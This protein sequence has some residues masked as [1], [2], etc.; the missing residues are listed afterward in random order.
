MLTCDSCKD[1]A[2]KGHELEKMPANCPMRD[3]E[4]YSAIMQE[5]QK[6]ENAEFLIQCAYV[7]SEGYGQWNRVRE[8]VELC[9]RM[10]YRKVGV[11]FCIGLK[12]EAKIFCK[13]LRD[14]GIAVESI[15]CKNGSY[16]KTEVGIPE[17]GKLKPGK[18]EPACNPVAQAWFLSQTDA[19]LFVMIG[20]CVGHDSLFLRYAARYTDVPVT[21]LAVKDR[22]TGH[23]PCAALYGAEGFFKKTFGKKTD[24]K[25]ER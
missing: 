6:E 15:C 21:V 22:V 10:N 17:D 23:N 1:V 11:A 25:S 3:T 20:L 13:I 2:C 16:D 24:E 18:F 9:R 5:Y 8:I 19:D 7:E 4:A 12:K 14:R